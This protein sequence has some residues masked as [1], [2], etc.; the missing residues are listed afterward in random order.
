MQELA[1]RTFAVEHE[2]WVL[3][4]FLKRDL[5]LFQVKICRVCNEYVGKIADGLLNVGVIQVRVRKVGHDQIDFSLIRGGSTQLRDVCVVT[6]IGTFG[7]FLWN[8]FK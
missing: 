7:N 6:L 1:R 4:Q 8:C 5:L 2:D 3:F